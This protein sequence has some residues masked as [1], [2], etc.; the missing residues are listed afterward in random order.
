M[1]SGS[2]EKLGIA[3]VE[4]TFPMAASGICLAGWRPEKSWHWQG[5]GS[6]PRSAAGTAQAGLLGQSQSALPGPALHAA[7]L[8]PMLRRLPGSSRRAGCG[9]WSG[10]RGGGSCQGQL[11]LR[12]DG[13]RG[14]AIVTPALLL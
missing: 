3:G 9:P 5:L 1:F 10:L 11:S 4:G 8:P 2:A 13:A 12:T 14:W 6:G 7:S